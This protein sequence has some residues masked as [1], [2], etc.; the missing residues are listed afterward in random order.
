MGPGLGLG[1]VGEQ[2]HDDGG[3][4]NVLVDVEEVLAG[5]PAILDGL[6]PRSTV[7]ADTDDDVEALVAEV[8]A[9]AVALGAV[10]DEGQSVVLEVVLG[11]NVSS[12]GQLMEN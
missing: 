11:S 3:L 6:L 4:A 8:E 5:D 7:L 2:V 1:G 10:A 12:R 9:L